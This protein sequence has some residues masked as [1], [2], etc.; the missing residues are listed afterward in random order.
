MEALIANGTCVEIRSPRKPE[1]VDENRDNPLRDWDGR[2][3][4]SPVRYR[5]S[6]AHYRTTR[7]AVIVALAPEGIASATETLTKLGRKFADAFNRLGSGRN[8]FIE[9][10]ER[11]ELFA[12][13]VA[14]VAAAEAHHGQQFSQAADALAE[15]AEE[16]R[17]W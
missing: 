6:V 13:L 4:I 11:E 3:H 9:T 14:A 17:I 12:S 1:W 10:E 16:V 2:D 15:G 5:K 8:P 7:R